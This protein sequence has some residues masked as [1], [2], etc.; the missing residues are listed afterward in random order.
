MVSFEYNGLYFFKNLGGR[1]TL[2]I[3]CHKNLIS[4]N[5]L[6]ILKN[7]SNIYLLVFFY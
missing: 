1:L 5:P 2:Q 7:I 6:F 4:Y 3:G